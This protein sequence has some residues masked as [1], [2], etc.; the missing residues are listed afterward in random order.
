MDIRDSLQQCTAVTVQ[1]NLSMENLMSL[2]KILY[3]MFV[4]FRPKGAFVA[5]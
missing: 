4:V 3:Y 1:L 5:E 2:V